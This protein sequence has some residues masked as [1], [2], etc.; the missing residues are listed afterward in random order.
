LLAK[1]NNPMFSLQ[2]FALEREKVR[3]NREKKNYR[4]SSLTN[5]CRKE[6]TADP[7]KPSTTELGLEKNGQQ[8]L[9]GT[10]IESNWGDFV[11]FSASLGKV[12][13]R[14]SKQKGRRRGTFPNKHKG[15][16]GESLGTWEQVFFKKDQLVVRARE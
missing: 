9:E 4:E 5:I 10:K 3:S 13:I 2:M 14:K 15:E 8:T 7:T 6:V 16:G 12:A 11:R 1:K